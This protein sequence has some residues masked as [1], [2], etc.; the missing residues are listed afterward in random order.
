V[1]VGIQRQRHSAVPEPL[2][3]DL[4]MHSCGQ[5]GCGVTM[6]EITEPNAGHVGAGD[7]SA[8]RMTT[9]VRLD[10]RL[11]SDARLGLFGTLDDAKLSP[12]EIAIANAPSIAMMDDAQP[13]SITPVTDFRFFDDPPPGRSA[14]DRK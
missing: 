13:Q 14:L 1:A 9:A 12:V 3:G 2:A 4:G 6:P 8:P 7:E 11:I 5:Q 10:R